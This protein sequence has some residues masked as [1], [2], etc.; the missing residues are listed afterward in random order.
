MLNV[1]EYISS[2]ILEAYALSQCTPEE[3]REV[4]RLML[5]DPQVSAEFSA[6][7]DALD[8]YG[9][10]F[11][12]T[13]PLHLKNKIWE[14]IEH[15]VPVTNSKVIPL[16]PKSE[17]SW[18]GKWMVA[19][20]LILLVIAA[21]MN[22]YLYSKWKSA[23]RQIAEIQTEKEFFASQFQVE[24]A[25]LALIKQELQ[26]IQLP[27]TK[28]IVMKGTGNHPEA[29]ATIFWNTASQEVFLKVNNLPQVPSGKQYQLWAIVEGA[30]V[31]AG[32]LD[33]INNQF[34]KMENFAAAQAFAVT[35]EPEGGSIAPT[36]EAMFVIGNI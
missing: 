26:F 11:T 15:Q 7:V 27:T 23:E 35:L 2:G 9:S 3:A 13:P 21:S 8:S 28:T 19:A 31:N 29:F 36:L 6:I 32:I 33:T 4:Q 16:Y 18:S 30:P 5:L 25:N 20:S 22:V 1:K 12:K 17:L 14:A 34:Q 24:K 10:A